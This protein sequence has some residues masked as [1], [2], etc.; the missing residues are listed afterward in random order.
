MKS[1]KDLTKFSLPFN[2]PFVTGGEI[3][4]IKKAQKN[5]HL[6]SD[7]EFTKKNINFFHSKLNIANILLTNTCTDALELIALLLDIK[8]DDEIIMPSFT[9]VSTANAF[10]LRGGKPVFVD[11]R[12]DTLNIDEKKI[13]K[14][15]TKKTKAIV[16]VHYAGVSCEINTILKICKKY[17]LDLIEDSAHAIMSRYN[18][19]YLGG[20]GSLGAFS[21]HETKNY[22]CGEGGALLINKKKYLKRAEILSEKG[23][24]RKKFFSGKIN[25]Y[26]WRDIG[27]SSLMSEISAA[28]LWS[29]LKNEKKIFNA[30]M[31]LW[32][33]YH[34]LLKNYETSKLI[35]RPI[36]PTK[37]F[38]NAHMY[39][40][41]LNKK[42]NRK[43]IIKEMK[44]MGINTVIHYIPLHH[45]PF[46][47]KYLKPNQKLP[48]T[49]NYSN[50]I[51]RLP[52]WIGLTLQKQKYIV[53][54][55]IKIINND[56]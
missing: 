53:N 17:K 47:K 40:V 18:N 48:V 45:S 39:Y 33:N 23:T 7:G 24:D 12:S 42:N 26:T 28:Y 14:S 6:S 19:R 51:L 37:C 35:R 50:R 34:K 27:S 46:G 44:N 2:V 31:T 16:I 49:E 10:V 9:F 5:K 41:I 3:K 36:V 25:K 21:F 56:K 29:Q 43:N 30:R 8:K 55:L 4:N 15:I 52:F 32:D 38:H 20:V 22:T 11:I 54:N 13:E 1:K